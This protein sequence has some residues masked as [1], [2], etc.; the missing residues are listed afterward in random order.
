[1]RNKCQVVEGLLSQHKSYFLFSCRLWFSEFIGLWV[2][3]QN[4]PQWEGVSTDYSSSLEE[5]HLK[6]PT[7]CYEVEQ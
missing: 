7:L 1:M 4:L 5:I 2:S 6:I 3:V